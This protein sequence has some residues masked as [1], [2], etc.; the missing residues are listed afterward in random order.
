MKYTII[1][2]THGT[3]IGAQ[4]LSETY[5]YYAVPI[6]HDEAQFIL[7]WMDAF[8]EGGVLHK[9]AT[10]LGYDDREIQWPEE[11][12]FRRNSCY[13]LSDSIEGLL[14]NEQVEFLSDNAE[15]RLVLTQGEFNC[16]AL[17]SH[18]YCVKDTSSK[19]IYPDD[20]VFRGD[21]SFYLAEGADG[22]FI[23]VIETIAIPRETIQYIV[24]PTK[25]N[26]RNGEKS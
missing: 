14:S 12:G 18:D 16:D 22:D 4:Q 17:N 11:I 8:K 15:N 1:G 13:F 9:A 2:R 26:T 21:C 24:D 7:H 25:S 6:D 3:H 10:M 23:G 19:C 20:V 5:P